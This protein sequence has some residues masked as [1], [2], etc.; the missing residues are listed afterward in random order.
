MTANIKSLVF[1]VIMTPF[2][3]YKNMLNF[4]GW[5][6]SYKNG[7]LLAKFQPGVLN[8]FV[9]RC[10][11]LLYM[12]LRLIRYMDKIKN[13]ILPAKAIFLKEEGQLIMLNNS[14]FVLPRMQGSLI[15]WWDSPSLHRDLR[16]ANSP[17]ASLKATPLVFEWVFLNTRQN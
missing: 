8:P 16:T 6:C 1:Y 13:S 11:C 14:I 15:Y 9:L 7:A 4:S 3:F 12:T 17:Y 10:G 2:P 5:S